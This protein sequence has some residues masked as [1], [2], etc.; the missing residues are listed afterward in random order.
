[1]TGYGRAKKT[2][3]N[4]DITVEVRSVNNRYLDCTVKLPRAYIFA[5]DAIKGRVQKAI[6]RGKV[7]VF[8]TIDSTGADEE[9]V[10]V[11]EG[12]ARSYLEALRKLYEID[13]GNYLQKQSYAAD[14]A[15]IPDVLTVTKAEEDLESVG[16]DICEVLDEAIA[17]YNQM[18]ATEGKKLAED[19]GGRLT[20]IETL[21]G[22]VEERSP[23]TVRE[24][25]E[26]LTARMQE[27][28]Q[29]TTIDESRI[30]TDADKVAVDEE[31]VRLRSHVSQLRDML[32]S[33]E[34]MGRKMDFLIQEVNRE[35][36]TIGSKCNDVAIARDVVALKAEVEKIREQVQNIE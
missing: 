15:R 29:S 18:R 8:V 1:M 7:D 9:V 12:L 32:L 23:E 35:S 5:E 11:N 36:N 27:V 19:I 21:T 2:L 28:L 26:K 16:A 17:S 14:L 13:G 4:R 31:T 30:L 34:P 33:D 24:Y 10:V 3:S 22:K 6:S 25:R 20:T